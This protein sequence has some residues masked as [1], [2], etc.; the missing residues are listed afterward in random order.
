MNVII[1]G[2]TDQPA[3]TWKYLV[4]IRKQWSEI[5]RDKGLG[6]IDLIFLLPVGDLRHPKNKLK[7]AHRNAYTV[8]K[9]I[10]EKKTGFYLNSFEGNRAQSDQGFYFNIE[11]VRSNQLAAS[12]WTYRIWKQSFDIEAK[13]KELNWIETLYY[14]KTSP[15]INVRMLMGTSS[16]NSSSS[17]T[18]C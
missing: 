4:Y 13:V 9:C 12:N 6:G 11:L 8:V 10:E 17:S 16:S 5:V 15:G 7:E 14:L 2:H 1:R 3:A 18:P